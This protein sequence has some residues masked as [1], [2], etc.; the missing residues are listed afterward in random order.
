MFK[1]R[2]GMYWHDGNEVFPKGT[3]KEVTAHDAKYTL[4]FILDPANKARLQS[5][6][7]A[8]IA[9]IEV[10]DNYTLKITTKEP[11]AFFLNDLGRIP[12]FSKEVRDKLGEDKFA[13]TPIGCGP[14]IFQEYRPDDRV[15][16]TRN[17]SFFIKP[18]VERVVFRIIPDK[19]VALMALE[20]GGI[21]IALQIPATEVARLKKENKVTV[22]RNTF[23]WYRYAAF[24]FNVPI[25][26][27]ATVRE[28]IAL[29]LNMNE[30]TRTI[31]PEESL[32]EPAYGPV[33]R[34]IPGFTDEWKKMWEYNP[35][36]AKKM[37]ADAGWK[38][39]KDGTLEKGNQKLSFSLKVHNDPNRQKMATLLATQLKAVG[40]DA[41]VQ[42]RDWATHLDEIRKGNVE[43][44]IMGG[45]STPDGLLYMFHTDI[46][47]GQAHMTSYN[48]A[49]LDALLD[50]AKATVDI[51]KRTAIWTEAATITVK[52]RV[53][54]GGFLEYVQ[55]GASKRVQEFD[56]PTPWVSLTNVK[57]NVG[58]APK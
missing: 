14:F 25:F 48:N 9:K 31:F 10:P 20:S 33:P 30:V 4:D 22:I 34:G 7:A 56:P 24:N 28:A 23:G 58:F 53:H 49:K 11:Y 44:F 3:K 45:G 2:K 43:M 46:S 50:K 40:V 12:I 36:K 55:I 6:M 29:S 37:L 16:L 21:D 47:K 15:I 5:T 19:S 38:A 57:R 13:K 1:I 35:D 26:K 54:L 17:D 27:D 32:A 39:G 8:T 52:D 42:V 18:R 51:D 41:K